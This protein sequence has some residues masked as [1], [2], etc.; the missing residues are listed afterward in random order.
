MGRR[1]LLAATVLLA[2]GCA[3][4]PAR[5]APPKRR[6]VSE[7]V[8]FELGKQF[9]REHQAKEVIARYEELLAAN[10]EDEATLNN[11]AWCLASSPDVTLR[12]TKRAIQLAQKA[13]DLSRGREPGPLDTLARCYF[14]D[15]QL[16]KAIETEGEAA[17][18][19][20]SNAAYQQALASHRQ[21]K[22]EA[23]AQARLRR[24]TGEGSAVEVELAP[25]ATKAP[26]R[27]LPA[28]AQAHLEEAR[29]LLGE[30]EWDRAR[31]ELQQVVAEV[32]DCAPAY[33]YLGAVSAH[34]GD[35]P[36]AIRLYEQAIQYDPQFAPAWNNLAWVLA[37]AGDEVFR[38]P[39]RAVASALRAVELTRSKDPDI[40]DTLAEAYF[41]AGR[42]Q[43]AV[44]AEQKALS[45]DAGARQPDAGAR[46]AGTEHYRRQLAR[47][48]EA[49]D[50]SA[51]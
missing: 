22:A 17:A 26:E 19:A 13:V 23:E 36:G 2:A 40:L 31:A 46:G 12:D 7:Q 48:L 35:V 10:P 29:R 25:A 1:F 11:L 14:A 15:G 37:T 44:E 42:L 51:H 5:E 27:Q 24:F 47:F 49:L 39:L 43:D 8:H 6:V 3:G 38:D 32:P 45:L 50:K 41:A 20:P 30:K 28:S 21:A 9:F 33:N 4:S 16:D 34:S 18:L